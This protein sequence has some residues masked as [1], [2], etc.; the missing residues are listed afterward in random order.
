[1]QLKEGWYNRAIYRYVKLLSLP[2][3]N[4]FKKEIFTIQANTHWNC[5][6]T[7][8]FYIK[9]GLKYQLFG[10]HADNLYFFLSLLGPMNLIIVIITA[11]EAELGFTMGF[12]WCVFLS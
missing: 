8:K 9:L 7:I 3:N 12:K 11:T 1:M 4:T 2:K 10:N 5:F 6:N